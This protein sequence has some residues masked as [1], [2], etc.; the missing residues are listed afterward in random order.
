MI[1]IGVVAVFSRR[2]LGTALLTGGPQRGAVVLADAHVLLLPG[3][4]V[5]PRLWGDN[6]RARCSCLLEEVTR[7]LEDV[8]LAGFVPR[9]ATGIP[10]WEISEQ[11]T[12]YA[13]VFD[14][15]ARRADDDSSNARPFELPRDQTHGLVADGSERNEQRDVDA[16]FATGADDRRRVLLDGAPL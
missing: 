4:G 10:E 11:E 5:V 8:S 13:A 12:G 9:A 3:A 15:V 2:Q 14:D 1:S 6:S 16:V 7:A